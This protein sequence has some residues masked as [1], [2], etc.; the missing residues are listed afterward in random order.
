M[1]VPCGDPRGLG[2]RLRDFL[3]ARIGLEQ[4]TVEQI[5]DPQ[6]AGLKIRR[7]LQR[8]EQSP[9]ELRG[10]RRKFVAD[11][12]Q[13]IEIEHRKVAPE[14]FQVDATRAAASQRFAPGVQEFPARLESTRLFAPS[15]P[16]SQGDGSASRSRIQLDDV[17]KVRHDHLGPLAGFALLRPDLDTHAAGCLRIRVVIDKVDVVLAEARAALPPAARERDPQRIE[18]RGLAGVVRADEYGR[19]SKIDDQTPD[20]PEV[21]DLDTRYA[22]VRQTLQLV[23]ISVNRC[24]ADRQQCP[25]RDTWFRSAM[26]GVFSHT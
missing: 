3:K 13:S 22:H 7:D 10:P 21:L 9:P 15:A 5:K 19:V 23:S 1:P 20:R 8:S 4:A 2:Q 25:V 6:R 14:A 11:V 12:T 24:S 26:Q 18:N 16:G 17:S